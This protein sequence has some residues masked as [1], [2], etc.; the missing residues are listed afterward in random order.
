MYFISRQLQ[1]VQG[2]HCGVVEVG[3]ML[4]SGFVQKNIRNVKHRV[5]DKESN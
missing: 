3:C 5:R 2:E 4:V 1:P